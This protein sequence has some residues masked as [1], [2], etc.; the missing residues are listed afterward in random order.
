MEKNPNTQTKKRQNNQK[1][2]K[3]VLHT[4]KKSS[5]EIR[6][7][8]FNDYYSIVSVLYSKRMEIIQATG[9]YRIPI[10]GF[11]LLGYH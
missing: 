6:N 9:N 2:Q 8:Q 10:C 4:K 1:K 11:T 5:S 7:V 3:L